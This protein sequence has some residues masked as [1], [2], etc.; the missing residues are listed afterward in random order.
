MTPTDKM[1]EMLKTIRTRAGD[2]NLGRVQRERD[3]LIALWKA[4]YPDAANERSEALKPLLMVGHHEPP[5]KQDPRKPREPDEQWAND[6]Y[7]IMVRRWKDD[8]VFGTRGGMVQ[9]GISSHDGTARHDWRHLQ[10]IKSQIA[11]PEVEGF[12]LFPAESRLL[13]PSN[14]YTIWCFPGLRRIKVGS[15]EGRRNWT[16]NEALAP[17]RD[18]PDPTT[19]AEIFREELGKA[20]EE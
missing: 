8:L 7:I 2:Y 19:L 3:E 6:L 15:E 12:E 17:Q 13:D 14:Y 18:Q 1:A 10:A 20:L 5:E 9:I 11:G 16:A 4:A